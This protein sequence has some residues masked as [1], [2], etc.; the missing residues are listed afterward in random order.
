MDADKDC[1]DN[2]VPPL[3]LLLLLLI[4]PI[5]HNENAEHEKAHIYI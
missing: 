3:L 2:I 4:Q 5:D 1:S